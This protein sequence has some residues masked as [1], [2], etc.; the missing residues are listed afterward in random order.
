M[1]VC[2]ICQHEFN[3]LKFQTE[4]ISICT[5]CVNTL[6]NSPEPARNSEM[7]FAEKLARGMQRNAERDLQSSESWIRD[8]ANRILENLDDAVSAKLH[9]WITQLLVKSTNSTRDFK[10]MRAYRRGLLR[11]DGFAEYPKGWADVARRI[12]CRDGY[13]CISCDAIDTT[14]DVHHIIYLSNHGTNQQSNL[15]TLCRKCHEE[16]HKRIFDWPEAK[17]PESV[18][19]ICPS[20]EAQSH[21]PTTPPLGQTSDNSIFSQAQSVLLEADRT[22]LGCPE[23]STQLT[24]PSNFALAGKKIRCPK[25]VFVFDF[26]GAFSSSLPE[27][28]LDHQEF[29]KPIEKTVA[30]RVRKPLSSQSDVSFAELQKNGHTGGEKKLKRANFLTKDLQILVFVVVTLFIFFLF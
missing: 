4:H 16:E 21:A 11:A 20:P 1:L 2:R 10:I 6:N 22:D 15:I 7:R 25:C 5:R 17:D 28:I 27:A 8:R 14:L 13:K 9:D 3:T 30:Q 12:R 23:C 18:N 26:A 19:P 29:S 24:I